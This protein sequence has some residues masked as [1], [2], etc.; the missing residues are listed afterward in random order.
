MAM[1]ILLLIIGVLLFIGLVVVLLG[2][3]LSV[4]LRRGGV[5]FGLGLGLLLSFMYWGAIQTSRAFGT[6]H[7]IS[8][9][10][11]AWLPNIVFG[12]FALILVLN[13]DR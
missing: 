8:A 3:P 9:A 6:S 10:L 1:A 7:V 11:A 4:R 5:M 2:L 12:A 13:V